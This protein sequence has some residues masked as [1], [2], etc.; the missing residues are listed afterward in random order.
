MFAF[1]LSGEDKQMWVCVCVIL[2]DT[3]CHFSKQIFEEV[4]EM[5]KLHGARWKEAELNKP[6]WGGAGKRLQ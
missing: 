1:K 6:L 2:W 3:Q 5:E 4:G